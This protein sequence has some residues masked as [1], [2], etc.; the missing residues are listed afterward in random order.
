MDTGGVAGAESTTDFIAVAVI[1]IAVGFIVYE[2]VQGIN[3]LSDL[4]G[5]WAGPIFGIGAAIVLVLT[6]VVLF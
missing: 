3:S 6:F 4:L 1:A 2:I 5:G